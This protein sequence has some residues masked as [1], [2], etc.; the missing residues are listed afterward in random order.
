MKLLLI[1]N[2]GSRAGRGQRRW[3]TWE[4][5]LQAAGVAYDCAA[6]K[7]LGHARQLAREATGYDTVVAV[8]GDGTINEVLDGLVQAGRPRQSMGVLYSG[9][10]PDF[11][12]FHRVP[13]RPAEALAALLSARTRE[14]DV[15]RISY[16]DGSGAVQVAHFAC[17]CNIGMGA[18]IARTANR[19]RRYLGDV[20]GTGLGVLLALAAN[21][22]ADLTLDIDGERVTL[23]ATNNLSVVKNPYLASGLR[24]ALDVSP[25]DGR[26]WLVGIAGRTPSG[27]CRLLPSFY[28]GR[29]T[30][31][32]GLLQ[33]SCR[34]VSISSPRP[35]EIEFDGDP[36]GFLPVQI[37]V[38]PRALRLVG[39]GDD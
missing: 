29:V 28:S 4:E 23:P 7:C 6:T 27:L 20:P 17:S 2:P 39:G 9:T 31:A 5:G 16:R 12:K 8:G 15:A 33:R 34:V 32:P 36:R 26:L 24:L 30:S 13:I 1:M 11:C 3:Q 21:T 14:V 25:G 37:E 10:S 18:A 38:L 22:R 35:A 19:W